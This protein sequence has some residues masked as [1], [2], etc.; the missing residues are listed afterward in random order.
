MWCFIAFFDSK[1][2]TIT[3]K[4][5]DNSGHILVLQVKIDDEIYLL[6]NLYNSNIEPE[7]LETLHELK[8]ILLK[9]GTNEYNYIN[10]YLDFNIIFNASL[11]ATG[12]DT[13][14][15]TRRLVNFWN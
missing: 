3:K 5:S 1:S 14:L 7:Q 9:F 15:K 4:I 13:K 2:V 11:E 8:S 6:V 10:F 12:G